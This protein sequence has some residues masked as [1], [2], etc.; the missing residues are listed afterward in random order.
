M[1]DS[2]DTFCKQVAGGQRSINIH[3]SIFCYLS[4]SSGRYVWRERSAEKEKP[5]RKAENPETHGSL[6]ETDRLE[7][8][9]E[10]IY[11]NGQEFWHQ[12]IEEITEGRMVYRHFS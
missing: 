11:E 9:E 7:S 10:K 12:R 1:F 2:G 5:M 6:W 8:G 4:L 3:R